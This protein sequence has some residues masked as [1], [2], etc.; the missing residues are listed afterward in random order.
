MACA[1]RPGFRGDLLLCDRR[2]VLCYP[3]CVRNR[4]RTCNAVHRIVCCVQCSLPCVGMRGL[5][6]EAFG[7]VAAA[8]ERYCPLK[9]CL[10][11]RIEPAY[12]VVEST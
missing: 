2:K 7:A 9:P 5:G 12:D 8:D 4:S 6:S 11:K 10:Q 1:D 3:D